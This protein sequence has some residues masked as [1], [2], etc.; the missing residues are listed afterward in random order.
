MNRSRVKGSEE[1]VVAWLNVTYYTR[2]HQQVGDIYLTTSI[3]PVQISA[4]NCN[5]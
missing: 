3:N 4:G 1:V 2:T 5:D